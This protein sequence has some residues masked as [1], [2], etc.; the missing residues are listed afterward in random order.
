MKNWERNLLRRSY[1]DESVRAIDKQGGFG[2]WRWAVF[3]IRRIMR[4]F[5]K[6]KALEEEGKFR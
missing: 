6:R 1:L 4:E 2:T 3:K 5:L